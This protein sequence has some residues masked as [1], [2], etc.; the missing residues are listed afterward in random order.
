MKLMNKNI[1][2]VLC[3]FIVLL[4]TLQSWSPIPIKAAG[5]GVNNLYIHYNRPDNNY[6]NW[7]VWLWPASQTGPN[8][9]QAFTPDT[10]GVVADI[11]VSQAT[12][13]E[14]GFIVRQ[15]D[16]SQKDPG[17][18]MGVVLQNQDNAGNMNIYIKS[19]DSKLYLD[20]AH[21]I[22]YTKPQLPALHTA[23]FTSE[24][25]LVLQGV[26]LY[27][28]DQSRYHV[29]VYDQDNQLLSGN[30]KDATADMITYTLNQH[31][32]DITKKYTAKLIENGTNTVQQTAVRFYKFFNTQLFN[33]IYTPDKTEQLG[34]T[35]S[36]AKT[37]FKLWTPTA[38]EVTLNVYD[39]PKSPVAMSYPMIKGEKGMWTYTHDA[40]LE[41][42]YY[43]YS[44]VNYGVRAETMD[45]YAQS[46]STNGLRGLIT[47]AEALIHRAGL[48]TDQYV[49]MKKQNDAIIYEAHIRDLTIGQS[50]NTPDALRGKYLGVIQSGTTTANG[51]PTGIDHI[52]SL[53]VTHVHFLPMFDYASV[54]ESKLSIP[55][56]NWGYDPLNYNV[57]EGSYTTDP[58][59]GYTRV[60]E[61]KQMISGMHQNKLGVVMDVVFNHTYSSDHAFQKT[62]PDYYYRQDEK[63]G[64]ANG[65]GVGNETASER[66]M[67]R[68]YMVDS[69]AHWAK[70]YKIDG[71]RFDLMG[72]HDITTMNE[73]AEKVRSINP[74][75]LIYGEGWDM[76]QLPSDQKASKV[77]VAKLNNIAVFNDDFRNGAKGPEFGGVGPGFVQGNQKEHNNLLFGFTS[78]NHPNRPEGYTGYATNTNQIVNYVSAH[79]NYTLYDKLQITQP[80]PGDEAEIHRMAKMSNALVMTS[81]GVPFL[82]A[83]VEMLRT[84]GGNE[85]SYNAPDRVNA[86]DY[87]RL[88]TNKDVVDYEKS[89]IQLRKDHPIFRMSTTEELASNLQF[90]QPDQS[91]QP[92]SKASVTG[93]TFAYTISGNSVSDSWQN[94][95]IGFNNSNQPQTYTLP[96]SGN[97]TTF[98]T[99]DV[100]DQKGIETREL[101]TV[102]LAPYTTLMM[103]REN[104]KPT[105][106]AQNQTVLKS[107]QPLDLFAHIQAK[108]V[109]DGDITSHI[110]MK[111]NTVDYTKAG[112]YEV[113]YSV[114]D[115]DQNTTE[116]AVTITVVDTNNQTENKIPVSTEKTEQLN[117]NTAIKTPVSEEAREFLPDTG[118]KKDFWS[119]FL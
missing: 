82:H 41:G 1:K 77:N 97:W 19:G 59:N 104:S 26:H 29:E 49:E 90:I 109:E 21:T 94:V 51:T 44:V 3:I 12:A 101:K 62:V 42:K 40:S 5:N 107:S 6:T 61:M 93:D 103:F 116:I 119:F 100:I 30:V 31:R 68:K 118:G 56:F 117:P 92:R 32:V 8:G 108:D 34:V 38:T 76:G 64:F 39:T 9:S 24:D 86:I 53:G 71:F 43:T 83:G 99:N 10:N 27:G 95:F 7:D 15:N 72:I 52:K 102:T 20:A 22:E 88:E 47:N 91:I 33:T 18:D 87:T 45:P 69:V 89:L 17:P 106:T 112:V 37:T 79:D 48:N 55:Q 23:S 85:N 96:V 50:T 13:T 46:A 28:G 57:P 114:T 60:K 67:M 63:G 78:M 84:K 2:A 16:W 115:S 54:D 35:L 73:V 70:A 110:I 98:G 105:I 74:Q 81:P 65:T 14:Y 113:V 36:D 11:D 75:A 66:V 111:K 58:E 80:H 4:V 25:T